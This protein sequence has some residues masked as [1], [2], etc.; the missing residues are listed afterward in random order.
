MA[1]T[2]GTTEDIILADLRIELMFPADD[3]TRAALLDRASEEQT[4]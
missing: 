1:L 4:A 2:T 3:R